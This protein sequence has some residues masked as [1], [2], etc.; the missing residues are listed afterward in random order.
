M[1]AFKDLPHDE[2]ALLLKALPDV[3]ARRIEQLLPEGMIRTIVLDEMR[4]ISER[5]SADDKRAGA[6]IA[7]RFIDML[8]KRAAARTFQLRQDGPEQKAAA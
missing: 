2:K 8:M 1:Q 3:H 6:Q 7:H 4:R 5:N